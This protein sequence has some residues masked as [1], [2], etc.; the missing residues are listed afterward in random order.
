MTW[1]GIDTSNYTTSLAVVSEE[2]IVQKRRLLRV[3][4]GAR[5]LRQSSAL[6]EHIKNLPQLWKE[7]L[8]ETDP[9]KIYAVGVSDRPRNAEG[10][11]MPVFLAGELAAEMISGALKKPLYRFSHQDGHIMAGIYTGGFFELLKK[12]FIS[13]H[14]SGGTTE[15]LL[16]RYNGHGFDN[17]IIGGTKDISAGQ[18]IDRVGVK[19]GLSFPCGRAL[20]E[21]AAD[22]GVKLPVSV[23]GAYM[24]FSGAETRAY[25]LAESAEPAG[26]AHGVLEAVGRT[27]YKALKYAAVE[28]AAED[29]LIV[30]GVASNKIIR[31]MLGSLGV[32]LYF[33]EPQYSTDNA[34]GIA[35]LAKEGYSNGY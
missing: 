14:L 29:V 22:R 27:L 16:T 3:P 12:R 13:V 24:N 30:G 6:F 25:Q 26:L 33:A 17:E 28:Y 21:L 10:S 15:I 34:V 4:E 18:L 1:L 31:E 9:S 11:Y 8:S 20:E 35:A 2:G 5:G 32:R 23:S 19:L 7:L